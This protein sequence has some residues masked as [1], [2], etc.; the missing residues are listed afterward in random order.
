MDDKSV[1]SLLST[2]VPRPGDIIET[3]IC[4]KLPAKYEK[5]LLLSVWLSMQIPMTEEMRNIY[6]NKIKLYDT[7]QEQILFYEQ[8]YKKEKELSHQCKKTISLYQKEQKLKHVETMEE[9][10]IGRDDL[11]REAF[12]DRLIEKLTKNRNIVI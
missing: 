12:I 1:L 11:L 5:L 2:F 3:K 9:K 6:F 10:I 8:F 4:A 7:K